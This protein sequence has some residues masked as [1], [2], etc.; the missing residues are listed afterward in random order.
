MQA[1][2]KLQHHVP[3]MCLFTGNTREEFTQ[4]ISKLFATKPTQNLVALVRTCENE[5][6][7]NV[8]NVFLPI[9]MNFQN[10]LTLDITTMC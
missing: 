6:F 7:N 10:N 5:S 4:G 1:K 8:K 3:H 2:E 9:R